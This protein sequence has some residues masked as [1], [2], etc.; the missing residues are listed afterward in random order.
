MHTLHDHVSFGISQTL[1]DTATDEFLDR[2]VAIYLPGGRLPA[3]P[4]A[5]T[6]RFTGVDTTS[7]PAGTQINRS[8]GQ[9]YTT[10]AS[11]TV[12]SVSP[13]LVDIVVTAE[14]PG[15]LGNTAEAV[16]LTLSSFITNID[17]ISTV[18]TPGLVSGT[19]TETDESVRQRMLDAIQFTPQSGA[20]HDYEIW[21][22]Q[23]TDVEQVFV[24]ANSE[25]FGLGTIKVQFSTFSGT[26]I[27][28]APK[29]A[30]VQAEID[31]ERP[32]TAS[33]LV[34][35]PV[36]FTANITM[37]IT[38]DTPSNQTAVTAEIQD[39]IKRTRSPGEVVTLSSIQIAALSAGVTTAVVT[40]PGSDIDPGTDGLINVVNVVY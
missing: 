5:G 24:F 16:E 15:S 28:G 11:G 29:V 38:P 7:V 36:A 23:V 25:A 20:L 12:G 35:A 34:E 4:A 19:D 27:P 6:V 26:E 18:Q 31:S 21:A 13:G 32:V 9:S 1:P 22:K 14:T 30:E 8:D 39:F 3:A 17:D 40:S 33:V 37:A 10:D 2:H